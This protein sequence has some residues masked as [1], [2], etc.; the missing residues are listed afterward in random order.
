[1]AAKPA[2]TSL[3]VGAVNVL[4]AERNWFSGWRKP[5]PTCQPKV[6]TGEYQWQPWMSLTET[7]PLWGEGARAY[8][9]DALERG[10]A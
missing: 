10:C 7:P 5:K 3:E 2:P 6:S 8:Y 1:M 4:L 9:E